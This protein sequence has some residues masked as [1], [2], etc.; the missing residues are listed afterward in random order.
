MKVNKLT[1]PTSPSDLNAR[2]RVLRREKTSVFDS[3]YPSLEG[4]S[5]QP[6][7]QSNLPR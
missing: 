7:H 4:G 5:S 6:G 3:R 2:G 1:Q